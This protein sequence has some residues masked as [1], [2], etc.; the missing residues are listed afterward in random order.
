MMR[1]GD[2]WPT[3]L[4]SS[5][6]HRSG[7]GRG[8]SMKS[9]VQHLLPALQTLCTE[10]LSVMARF[11]ASNLER[12]PKKS[13]GTTHDR[14]APRSRCCTS[15]AGAGRLPDRTTPWCRSRNSSGA[16]PAE[17]LRHRVASTRCSSSIR[18]ANTWLVCAP[19]ISCACSSV[20]KNF[21]EH[22]EHNPWASGPERPPPTALFT[23]EE[24]PNAS[25]R[26]PKHRACR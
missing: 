8:R 7:A 4:R 9:E 2:R 25:Q 23:L 21:C 26:A 3:P 15:R 5:V 12:V 17:V 11:N 22:A 16:T 6:L 14:R 10:V 1:G 18:W 24:M 19:T 13:S 20:A